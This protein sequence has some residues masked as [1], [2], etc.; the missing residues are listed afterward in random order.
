[1]KKFLGVATLVLLIANGAFSQAAYDADKVKAAMHVILDSMKVVKK[2]IAATDAKATSDAFLVV[3]DACKLML[4]MNPPQV[5]KKEG[6]KKEWDKQFS[7]II[8]SAKKGSTFALANDWDNAKLC[9]KKINDT[10]VP[11]HKAFKS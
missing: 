4:K 10:L 6:D 9:M 8:D 11:G 2:G 7:A 3:A 5:D 1:M